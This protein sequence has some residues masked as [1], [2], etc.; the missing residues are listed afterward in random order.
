MSLIRKSGSLRGDNESKPK[1]QNVQ[2]FA[3]ASIRGKGKVC[4]KYIEI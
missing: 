1:E 4:Y 3:P 2:R